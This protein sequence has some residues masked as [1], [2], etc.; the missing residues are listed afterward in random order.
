MWGDL[1]G[2]WRAARQR[3]KQEPY[4]AVVE[5]LEDRLGDEEDLPSVTSYD[6]QKSI[7]CLIRRNG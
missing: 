5:D 3:Q 7:C 4:L 2:C 6:K 1:S